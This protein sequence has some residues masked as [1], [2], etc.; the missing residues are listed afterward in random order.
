MNVLVTSSIHLSVGNI[1]FFC[2]TAKAHRLDSFLLLL[3][4]LRHSAG[5]IIDTLRNMNVLVLFPE[6]GEHYTSRQS[7]IVFPFFTC[8]FS[9]CIYANVVTT[10]GTQIINKKIPF[11]NTDLS[12]T[13]K[14]RTSRI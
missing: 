10:R 4:H 11:S 1:L 3:R 5:N 14:N 6:K 13:D 9:R 2:P 8:P 7:S 12:N